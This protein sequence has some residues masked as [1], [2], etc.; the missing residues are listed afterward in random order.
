MLVALHFLVVFAVW[1][2]L[3]LL[4][5]GTV[6]ELPMPAALLM[7]VA[8]GLL[9]AGAGHAVLRRRSRPADTGSG[10]SDGRYLLIVTL[11]TFILVLAFR[12]ALRE[13]LEPRGPTR[14]GP[15]VVEVASSLVVLGSVAYSRQR[16]LPSAGRARDAAP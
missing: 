3:Y 13:L 10:A 1:A 15:L 6:L 4:G 16:G 11:V 7:A 12:D 8:A 2:L 14:W 9:N 5:P